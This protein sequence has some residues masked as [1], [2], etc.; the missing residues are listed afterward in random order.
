MRGDGQSEPMELIFSEP[1]SNAA[2]EHAMRMA[3]SLLGTIYDDYARWQKERAS[4]APEARQPEPMLA[5][6][7]GGSGPR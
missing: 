7:W 5:T 3:K 1:P 2:M 4:G 6:K